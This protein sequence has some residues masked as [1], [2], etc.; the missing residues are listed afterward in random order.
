MMDK[1]TLKFI[2]ILLIIIFSY[3]LG[4]LQIHSDL[5]SKNFIKNAFKPIS[6]TT[7]PYITIDPSPISSDCPTVETKMQS[8]RVEEEAENNLSS[9]EI[10][11]RYSNTEE[12]I[13]KVEILEKKLLTPQPYNELYSQISNKKED[14]DWVIKYPKEWHLYRIKRRVTEKKEGA[15]SQEY[16][17]IKFEYFDSYFYLRE[18]I[19]LGGQPIILTENQLKQLERYC[20]T[21]FKKTANGRKNYLCPGNIMNCLINDYKAT[22]HP[23]NLYYKSFLSANGFSI[24]DWYIPSLLFDRNLS[25]ERALRIY[26]LSNN[27]FSNDKKFI[28]EIERIYITLQEKP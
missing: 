18:S 17:D 5:M 21:P 7:T 1:N 3:Y 8:D 4:T 19:T 10:K 27:F 12:K 2:G 20:E 9:Y 28:S 24:Y 14:P 26:T 23:I 11:E 16:Y 15:I 13:L 25:N 6:S 22:T